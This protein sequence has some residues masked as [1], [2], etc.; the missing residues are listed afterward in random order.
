MRADA[1]RSRRLLLDAAC[2]LFVEVGIGV[3]LE[4][5]ARRAG[6]G[7]ATLY[8]HFPDRLALVKAVAIDVMVRTGDEARAALA[9]EPDGFAALRRYMHRALD[10]CAPAIMPLL[11]DEVRRAPEV[12]AL[13]DSTAAAQGQL[14]ASAQRE[15]SLRAGVT[16]ADIGLSLARFSRPIGHGF[17]PGLEATVAHRH[18]DVFIDGLRHDVNPPLPDLALTLQDL[19][20]MRERGDSRPTT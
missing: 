17:D 15:G 4:A 10:V 1:Q 19:R 3:A 13:L 8:R 9:E 7:I 20:A 16:F 14:I 11:G 12:K 18:L 2:E 5:V 6:V